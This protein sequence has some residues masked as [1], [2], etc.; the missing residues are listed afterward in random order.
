MLK[1]DL[2]DKEV[3]RARITKAL[4]HPIRVAI[5]EMLA[6]QKCCFHG[7]MSEVLLVA[8]STLSQHLKKLREVGFIQ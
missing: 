7:N 4:S 3:E 2:A 5:L 8:K 1:R 6:S